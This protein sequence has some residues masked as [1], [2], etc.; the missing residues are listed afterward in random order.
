MAGDWGPSLLAL[1]GEFFG[2]YAEVDS[3]TK[4]ARRLKAD[5]AAGWADAIISKRFRFV[6]RRWLRRSS[7]EDGFHDRASAAPSGCPLRRGGQAGIS[8]FGEERS[9]KR[10]GAGS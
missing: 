9:S 5:V 1:F 10:R 4:I 6:H 2:G 3:L 7:Q 8:G